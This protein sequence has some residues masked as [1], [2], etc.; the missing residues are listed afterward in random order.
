MRAFYFSVLLAASLTLRA[1]SPDAAQEAEKE[2]FA[3]RY[4]NAAVLYAKLLH[5]DPA[6]APGY[7]GVVRALIGAYRPHEAYA[8]AAEG[9]LH[10]PETADVQAAAGMA[11]FRGGDLAKAET[12]FRKALKI[13]PN[14]AGA[15]SGLASIYS[16]ASKFKTA[17]KLMIAAYRALPN[18]PRLITEWANTLQGAEHVAA[19]EQALAIYDPGSREAR[20]LRAHIAADN[21]GHDRKLRRLTSPYESYEIKLAPILAGPNKVYGVGLRVL[22]NKKDVG[23]LLLDTGASGISISPKAAEKAGLEVLG[24]E[25]MEARGIGDRKPQD[26]FRYLAAE[27]SISDVTFADFPVSVFQS[28][29]TSD[30]DGLIGADVFQRFLVTIDF[31]GMQ[32]ALDP[33]PGAPPP[34]NE[35]Q[36]SVDPLPGGFFRVFRFG[37]YLTIPVSVNERAPRLF[38]IDSGGSINLIDTAV[39][40]ESTKVHGDDRTQLRG[41]QGKVKDV[42]RADRASLVFAGFRQDNSDLLATNLESSGNSSGVGLAGILGMPVLWQMK[43]TIDYRNGAVRFEHKKP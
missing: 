35:P 11:A 23:R 27:V 5:D 13:A 7:Y 19:L 18:D 32:L 20:A 21:A 36:D 33:Y 17:R 14:Y 39:A 40:E 4:D 15:L 26:S 9:L 6:W 29:K 43:M 24:N 25:S 10:A 8:A 38:L 28:A 30:V 1:A 37:H 12:S 2:L 22:L 34:A 41:I 16:S 31:K 3:A 42:A